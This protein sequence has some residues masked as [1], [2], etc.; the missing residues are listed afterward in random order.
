MGVIITLR[1]KVFK[2]GNKVSLNPVYPIYLKDLT[3]V[4]TTSVEVVSNK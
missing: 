4:N 3:I 1:S 2:Q